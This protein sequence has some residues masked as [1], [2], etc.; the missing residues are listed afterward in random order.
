MNPVAFGRL[1][2]GKSVKLSW[3][4][5]QLSF[6]LETTSFAYLMENSVNECVFDLGDIVNPLSVGLLF[7]KPEMWD[8]PG[9]VVVRDLS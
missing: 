2:S 3:R 8:K 6:N 5:E 9:G 7:R 1:L 4:Y